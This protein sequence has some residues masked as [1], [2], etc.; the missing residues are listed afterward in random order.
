MYVP[1]GIVISGKEFQI[2]CEVLNTRPPPIFTWQTPPNTQIVNV[3]QKNQPMTMNSK[4]FKSISTI[5]LIA[6]ISQHGQEIKCEATHIA[7]NKSL[8]GTAIIA[9]DCKF[10]FKFYS[11]IRN[12]MLFFLL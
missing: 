5:T 2:N 10:L 6:N 12:L 7:L 8:I 9:V 11:S 1:P 3:S 4:L